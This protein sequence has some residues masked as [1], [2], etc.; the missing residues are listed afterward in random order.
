MLRD[1]DENDEWTIP[2]EIELQDIV[3]ASDGLLWLDLREARGGNVNIRPSTRSKRE[4]YRD[5]D[6]DE[7]GVEAEDLGV[8][9]N[10][11][12]EVNTLDDVDSDGEPLDCS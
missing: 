6:D 10:L 2:T 4:R 3:N 8:S 1:V 7:I 11:E 5:D 9:D 12:E